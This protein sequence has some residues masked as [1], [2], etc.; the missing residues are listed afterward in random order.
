VDFEEALVPIENDEHVCYIIGL[1]MNEPSVSI[2]VEHEDDDNW[3]QVKD[4]VLEGGGLEELD[5]SLSD[6][7]F[8][9][10]FDGDDVQSETND[11]DISLLRETIK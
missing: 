8:E 9:L 1:L 6:P 10:C 11:E 4:D 2:Y 7:D 5:I 3:L